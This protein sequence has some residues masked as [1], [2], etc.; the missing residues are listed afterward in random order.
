MSHF[1][2]RYK[3]KLFLSHKPYN[4][5]QPAIKFLIVNQ[6]RLDLQCMFTLCIFLHVLA[7]TSSRHGHVSP[8]IWQMPAISLCALDRPVDAFNQLIGS[9]SK[10]YSTQRQVKG[11][12]LPTNGLGRFIADVHSVLAHRY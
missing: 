11:I 2:W 4:P 1:F 3:Q 8:D 10:S 12:D 5:P 6:T 9:Q 7:W